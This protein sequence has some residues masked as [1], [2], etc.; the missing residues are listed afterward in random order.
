MSAASRALRATSE[1]QIHDDVSLDDLREILAA[2]VRNTEAE[3]GDHNRGHN[4]YL[5]EE[6]R[7]LFAH[8]LYSDADGMLKHLKE[9]DQESVGRL[10]SSV[11]VLDLRIYGATNEE[12]KGL[13]DGFGKARYFDFIDG[14]VR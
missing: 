3:P 10:M 8:E 14:F 13:L 7:I 1:M 6:K 9:M 5:D 2:V 12:L 11:D 4:F